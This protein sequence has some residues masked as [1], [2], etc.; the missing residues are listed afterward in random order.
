MILNIL[1]ELSNHITCVLSFESF[2]VSVHVVLLCL[3][4]IIWTLTKPSMDGTMAEYLAGIPGLDKATKNE[5]QTFGGMKKCS[6]LYY[7][8]S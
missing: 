2:Q 8:D 1:R 7:H 3:I 6:C 4:V 5:N